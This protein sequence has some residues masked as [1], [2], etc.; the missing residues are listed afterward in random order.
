VIAKNI[1]SRS[2]RQNEN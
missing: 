2:K 1:V